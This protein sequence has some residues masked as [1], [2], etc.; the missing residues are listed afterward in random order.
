ML[1][2]LYGPFIFYNGDVGN[3]IETAGLRQG[4]FQSFAGGLNVHTNWG[5]SGNTTSRYHVEFAPSGVSTSRLYDSDAIPGLGAANYAW[6][7]GLVEM[8]GLP[9]NND[10]ADQVVAT[11][12]SNQDDG[13]IYYG[14][15]LSKLGAGSSN[16]QYQM[17]RI[18]NNTPTLV[19]ATSGT[20]NGSD[21]AGAPFPT[22]WFECVIRLSDKFV[23]WWVDGTEITS[24]SFTDY[25]GGLTVVC[26]GK[27][28]LRAYKFAGKASS[29][30]KVVHANWV[31]S[32]DVQTG[33]SILYHGASG[34]TP[35][36]TA[37]KN[38]M[39]HQ[40]ECDVTGKDDATPSPDPG[41]GLHW[42]NI[43]DQNDADYYPPGGPWSP[44]DLLT[45]PNNVAGSQM[46]G[47]ASQDGGS[48]TVEGVC[49]FI[50]YTSPAGEASNNFTTDFK[51][52]AFL[53]GGPLSEYTVL[54][55]S[56]ED[57]WVWWVNLPEKPGGGSWTLTDFNNLRVGIKRET[58]RDRNYQIRAIT[59]GVIGT[60][61]VQPTT[62]IASPA[63][64][65][66]DGPV[67]AA[68]AFVPRVMVY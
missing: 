1:R 52:L 44:T 34:I 30:Y 19:G 65:T 27:L 54:G 33:S 60:N 39:L 40:V 45:F 31:V 48:A 3:G 46:A 4:F 24:G 29:A 66:V 58:A 25:T 6:Y 21:S 9:A 57:H 49:L 17:C 28:E 50:G 43:D 38:L 41:S 61:L 13:G 47:V 42:S 2:A 67:A 22:H 12:Y 63:S 51:F 32:D 59:L 37:Y 20:F 18:N 14:L 8:R 68:A 15:A 53:S 26:D 10:T 55:S 16:F 56:A 62:T 7:G 23:R 36:G 64:C 5:G 35:L 11:F